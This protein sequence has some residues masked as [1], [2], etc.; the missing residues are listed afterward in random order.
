[1][2]CERLTGSFKRA[3]KDKIRPD[4]TAICL[5][6]EWL[7]P[8]RDEMGGLREAN[9]PEISSR[10]RERSKSNR[11]PEWNNLKSIARPFE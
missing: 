8:V 3:N 5:P 10:A 9:R 2:F 6:L 11:E 4:S 1:M 7:E